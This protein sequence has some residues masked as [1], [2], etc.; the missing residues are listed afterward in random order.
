MVQDDIAITGA[1]SQNYQ[2]N[3]AGKYSVRVD[4]SGCQAN[5]TIQLQEFM[6]K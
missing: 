3:A 2:T 5:A 4:Y 6:V 1:T